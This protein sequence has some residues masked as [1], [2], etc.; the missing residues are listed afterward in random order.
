MALDKGPSITDQLIKQGYIR[1]TTQGYLFTSQGLEWLMTA[2]QELYHEIERVHQDIDR[3]VGDDTPSR[4][5]SEGDQ[6]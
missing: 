5:G 6:V 3:I 4:N 2:L 1:T